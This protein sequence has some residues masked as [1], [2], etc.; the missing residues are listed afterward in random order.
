[1]YKILSHASGKRYGDP[2]MPLNQQ[3][4]KALL[5]LIHKKDLRINVSS[6]WENFVK[7]INLPDAIV[8]DIKDVFSLQEII[9]T[10]YELN[11]AKAPQNRI[12]VRAASGAIFQK[13]RESY[14]LTDGAVGDIIIRLNGEAFRKIKMTDQKNIVSVGASVE[15]G[16]L[17]KRL[18]AKH[19]LSLPTSSLISYV[20]V[21]GLSANAG[22]GTGKDQPSFA[23]LIRS[24]TLCLP[25]GKIVTIDKT[26]KNF[27]I[28]RAAH[29]GLF[30]IVINLELECIEAKKLQC[31]METRSLPEFLEEIKAGLYVHDPYVSA[32]YVPTYQ[33]DELTN[34]KLKNVIIYR[35][36]PV[37]KNANNINYHPTLAHLDQKLE[38]KLTEMFHIMD[39]LRLVPSLIPYYM[40]YLASQTSV[41][42]KDSISVGPWPI[43]HYQTVFPRK[44]N[45][46][47]CLF[48]VSNDC[49]ELIGSFEKLVESLTER[50]KN[51]EY[52]IAYAAYARLF[53]GTNGGLSTSSRQ[54]G[55]YV[56]GF[57]IVS[58]PNFPSFE[59]FRDEMT[60]FFIDTLNAKLHWGKYVPKDL[61]YPELYG[62]DYIQF[63]RALNEWYSEHNLKLEESMLLN[64]FFCD[65]LKLPYHPSFVETSANP[66]IQRVAVPLT[67]IKTEQKKIAVNE[68]ENKQVVN[69]QKYVRPILLN[70]VLSNSKQTLFS[71]N[72][73]TIQDE[74]PEETTKDF[75]LARHSRESP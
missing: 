16:E 4:K 5:K 67:Q 60:S 68:D 63:M 56:C 26:H 61:D 47:D 15:I 45:D 37:D 24:L 49:H 18:Y 21:A 46:L 74:Q 27:E 23:G 11:Q 71:A 3:D 28:I 50:A 30:G 59:K 31:V 33:T 7:N 57:D 32:M 19:N 40:R 54:P 25:N 8:L 9:R 66:T 14:S 1:M 75:P 36:R 70:T 55:E 10:V 34:K 64:T 2:F 73:R 42:N 51:K 65:V 38:I 6:G 44:I 69:L 29:L 53:S 12:L 17:D 41:G 39:L 72:H 20:T 58:V 22:H 43:I 48:E 62:R 35:W 13:N 52:P